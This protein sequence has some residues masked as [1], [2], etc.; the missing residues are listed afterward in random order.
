MIQY[1]L[2]V[3]TFKC[4]LVFGIMFI[5]TVTAF[6]QAPYIVPEK[7]PHEQWPEDGQMV[8]KD[9]SVRYREGLPLTIKS[10]SCS[11]SSTD[12]VVKASRI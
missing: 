9:L 12:K 4:N 6:F 5:S 11:I 10:I 8:I 1:F 2:T 3:P 7:R